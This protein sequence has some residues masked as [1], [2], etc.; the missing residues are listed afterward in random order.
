MEFTVHGV[1]PHDCYDT[2]SLDVVVRD[3]VIE[4]IRGDREHPITRGFLCFKV[5]RYLER[6]NHR[7]RILYP[8]RRVGSKGQGEFERVSWDLALTEIATR[9][10]DIERRSGA[11][12]ILPYSF[13]GNMG[14][15]SSSSMD[16]RFFSAIGASRLART[17]CTASSTAVLHHMFGQALGP[18]PETLPQARLILLWG[19]NPM[20]TNVHQIPLLDEAR[21][22]GAKIW[23]IDPLYTETAQRF[24]PH[25]AIHPNTDAVLAMGIGRYL[26]EHELYDAQYVRQFTRGFDAYREMVAPYSIEH[27]ARLC[28]V[29]PL[30]VRQLAEEIGKIRPLLIRPGYGMQ[31]QRDAGLAVWAVSALAIITGAF[32][33]AGGGLLIGNGDAFVLNLSALTRPDLAWGPTRSINMIELGQALTHTTNPSIEALVVYNANPAA[34]APDQS[35][36][37]KGLSRDDLFLVVHEQMMTDTARYADFVLPAAMSMEVLDMHV[38]YW[39]RY[40]QLNRPAVA[41]AGEAVSNPEFFRRLAHAMGLSDPAFDE[42]DEDLIRHALNTEHPYLAGVTLESLSQTPVKKLSLP[43]TAR[44][45]VDTPILTQDGLLHLDP[46]PGLACHED[47]PKGFHLLSPSRRETIKSSF[48]NLPS[49]EEREPDPEILVSEEDASSRGWTSGQWVRVYNAKG[50]TRCRVN[51]SPVPPSGTVVSYAVRW[52]SVAKGTNINQLTS[53]QLADFGGGATFYST[54][55]EIDPELGG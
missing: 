32:R 8:M 50:Q 43:M 20:A 31:R 13:A 52:N 23:T 35:R 15:L 34:T 45:F 41:P 6:I 1:C 33:N 49:F 5:N 9:L 25:M 14:I 54:W 48:A 36:V 24:K 28:G 26:I 17:I 30:Q 18:D 46:I 37:L 10:K 22:A 38:S 47:K 27:V 55:V 29:D 3:G 12:A 39:H 42:S 53:D 40:V 21:D 51:V 7:D 44:P 11:E 4:R 16:A 19:T 2:C